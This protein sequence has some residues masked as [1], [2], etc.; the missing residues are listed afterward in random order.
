MKMSITRIRPLYDQK[1][2]LIGYLD[3]F[4]GEKYGFPVITSKKENPY[5][6]GWIMNSQEGSRLLAKD[7]EIKGE[8]HRVLRLIESI[9]DFENWIYISISDIA[10]ELEMNR[11]SVSRDIKLLEKKEIILKGPKIG[12]SNTFMLNPY[13]TWKGKIKNLEKYRE[14]REQEK[15]KNLRDKSKEEKLKELSK[16]YNMPIDKLIELQAKLN[17]T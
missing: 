8:T 12:K 5:S 3:I 13:F 10:K 6:R 7:K 14:G 1:D 11:R 9:L 17:L 2:R 15:I 16:E 4:T